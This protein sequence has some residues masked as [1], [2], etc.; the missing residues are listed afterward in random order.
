MNDFESMSIAELQAAIEKTTKILSEAENK[1]NNNKESLADVQKEIEPVL[2]K[3]RELAN[4]KSIIEKLIKE[5]TPFLKDTRSELS[6]LQHILHMKQMAQ[7]KLSENKKF[8]SELDT[9]TANAKWR[10]WAFTHQID[11]AKQ[12]ALTGG[13]AILGD[14]RGLGKTLTSLITA[15]MVQSKKIIVFAPKET[16]RNFEN[17]IRDW[18]PDRTLISLVSEPKQRRDFLF[19][20][21]LP[22]ANEYIITMNLEAWRRDE[23]LIDKIIALQLDTVIIDEAHFIKESK[24][25]TAKGIARIVHAKNMC[26]MCGENNLAFDGKFFKCLTKDC[27]STYNTRDINAKSVKHVIPMTGTYILNSP[28]DLWQLLNLIDEENFPKV[29]DFLNHYCYNLGGNN[30]TFRYGGEKA[31]V[32]KLGAQ[33]IQRDRKT[34]GIVI[35]PQK[36]QFYDIEFD[37]ERY[38]EQYKAYRELQEQWTIFSNTNPEEQMNITLMITHILR[39]RQMLVWPNAIKWLD[40]ISKAPL[41]QCDVTESIKLDKAV[42]LASEFI[43]EGERV[44]L[45][46]QFVPPFHELAKRLSTTPVASQGGRL[47]K[48]ALLYGGTSEK[49][50][51]H[52]RFDFDAKNKSSDYDIVLAQ[53]RV[54]GQSLNFTGATQMIIL[55]EEWN[56]GK[57]DQA[58]GRIDRIGQSKETTV[59]VLQI[60]NTVDTFMRMLNQKKAD[61]INGFEGQVNLFQEMMKAIEKGEM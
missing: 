30:W 47:I 26:V 27:G 40:P 35:P 52:I 37:K 4:Q 56:P 31:L 54:G 21:V 18:A 23:Y 12:I 55:D 49:E 17:E 48:P 1:N 45:F 10:E 15:D 24:T 5:M 44:V 25:V 57:N 58:Y 29:E 59:H 32:E 39:S 41:F 28:K 60:I 19:D 20:F 22:D 8:F 16:I 13:R 42:E 14:K 2:A 11:G 51:E 33:L 36:I 38:P 50:R 6:E 9:L 34:A 53:Y 3:Y 7:L 46:S 43:E 61:I